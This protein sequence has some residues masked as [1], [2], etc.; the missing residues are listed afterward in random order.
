M[1][2]AIAE[3]A[4]VVIAGHLQPV[5]SDRARH[6]DVVDL[7]RCIVI[8]DIVCATSRDHAFEGARD[9]DRIVIVK[10]QQWRADRCKK[11]N[12]KELFHVAGG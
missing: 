2:P 6:H 3:G 9:T 5:F 11:Q 8:Q 10:S 4:A 1:A 12:E 7:P